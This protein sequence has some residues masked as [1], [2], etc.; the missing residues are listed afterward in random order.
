MSDIKKIEFGKVVNEILF[1]GSGQR[2]ELNV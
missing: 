1:Y 2:K